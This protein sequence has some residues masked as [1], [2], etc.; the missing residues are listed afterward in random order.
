MPVQVPDVLHVVEVLREPAAHVAGLLSSSSQDSEME[1][2]GMSEVRYKC[3]LS[4]SGMYYPVFCSERWDETHRSFTPCCL[5]WTRLLKVTFALLGNT[6]SVN[7]FGRQRNP[8]KEECKEVHPKLN[9]S[10]YAIP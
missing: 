10:E 3:L 6:Q 9:T 2:Q 4:H 1:Q 8:T 5:F 7:I